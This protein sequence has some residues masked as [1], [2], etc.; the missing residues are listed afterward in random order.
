MVL[1]W[2]IMITS[3]VIDWCPTHGVFWIHL[4]P[5]LNKALIKKKEE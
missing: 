5:D 2:Y 4:C 3:P 1:L